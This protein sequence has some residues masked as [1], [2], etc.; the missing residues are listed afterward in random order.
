MEANGLPPVRS[1]AAAPA[2]RKV[3]RRRLIA[4]AFLRSPICSNASRACRSETIGQ[5]PLLRFPAHTSAVRQTSHGVGGV[6]PSTKVLCRAAASGRDT[7]ALTLRPVCPGCG[8][9]RYLRIRARSTSMLTT[10]A[11]VPLLRRINSVAVPLT[12]ATASRNTRPIFTLAGMSAESRG[13]CLTS[14]RPAVTK[15]I[16][17]TGAT[18]HERGDLR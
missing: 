15:A 8:S 5:K 12:S 18:V 16:L 10:T 9:P 1:V 11:V 7:G 6:Y 2:A 13:G 17:A 14:W 4:A 3:R